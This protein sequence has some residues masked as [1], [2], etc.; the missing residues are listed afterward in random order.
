MSYRRRADFDRPSAES[1]QRSRRSLIW[2][3]P[4]VI[5]QQGTAIFRHDAD[6][7]SKLL[8]TAAWAAV[9]LTILWMLLAV[10]LRWL[11]EEDQAILNDEWNRSVTGDASRWG[12]AAMALIGCVMMVARIWVQLDAGLAIYALVNGAL[13]VAIARYWW[14]NRGEPAEDE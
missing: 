2:V 13:I 8:T 1:I 9:T 7:A 14:L 10:P 6:L 3:I 11:P 5:L 12:I 4:L